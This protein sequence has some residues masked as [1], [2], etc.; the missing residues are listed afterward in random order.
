M[1]RSKRY[2]EA[3]SKFDKNKKYSLKEAIDI[4]KATATAKCQESVD[5]AVK[6]NINTKK[7]DQM[8]RGTCDL[9]YGTGKTKKILVLTKG[10]KEKEAK[11][12]GADYVGFEEYI[13]KIKSG[14]ID[15]DSVIATPD[16]MPEVGKLGKI[17]G[18]KGLMPSPKTG[19]VTFEVGP[20]V[21][22]LKKGKIEFKSD[23]GGCVHALVG[24]VTFPPE[25][26]EANI[27]TFIQDLIN[28]RPPTVKGQFIKSITIS[29]T[30]GPG[31][32]LNEKEFLKS[33]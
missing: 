31:I 4:L 7:Q 28:A 26:L 10:E 25:H 20:Q 6:L 11:E 22:A 19:T 29:S 15:F 16:A 32:K 30:F 21:K 8:V 5:I 27:Q 1:K 33:K 18:P 17:L 14:W 24:K 3:L 13:E 12:A 23:K 9:P 2:T